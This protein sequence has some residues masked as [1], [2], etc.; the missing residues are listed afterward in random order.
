MSQ[1]RRNMKRYADELIGDYNLFGVELDDDEFIEP[2]KR[3][4]TLSGKMMDGTS[5]TGKMVV[6]INKKGNQIDKI[7]MSFPYS[8]K[9]YRDAYLMVEEN[10]S[11]YNKFKKACAGKYEKRFEAISNLLGND[12][13][14]YQKGVDMY[15]RLPGVSD[16]NVY[17][18]DFD[19]I[20]ETNWL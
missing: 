18:Y 17:L 4:I 5:Y 14:T 10:F 11:N 15:E 13:N 19:A 20:K 8:E 3:L 7:T 1:A 6:Y 12:T 16:V 2:K 9:Q